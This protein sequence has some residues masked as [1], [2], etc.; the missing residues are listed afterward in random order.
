M[1]VH[2]NLPVIN[3][4][5]EHLLQRLLGCKHVSKVLCTMIADSIDGKLGHS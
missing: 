3:C 4:I 1:A 5:V 2:S